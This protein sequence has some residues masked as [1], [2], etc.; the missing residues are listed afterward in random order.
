MGLG[1]FQKHR[2]EREDL[3]LEELAAAVDA[4]EGDEARA[5]AQ[6]ALDLAREH[7][8]RS[9][10]HLDDAEGDRPLVD[11]SARGVEVPPAD[12]TTRQDGETSADNGGQGNAGVDGDG[13]PIDPNA[14]KPEDQ[15]QGDETRQEGETS[16][17]NGGQGNAGV[18]GD[19]E[20]EDNQTRVPK[21]AGNGSREAW[22]SYAFDN[23]KTPED[24]DGLS[25]DDIRE[26]FAD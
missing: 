6:E 4:A 1:M 15:E 7:A 10:A 23:G 9:E 22:A 16:A 19:G 8:G 20:P 5:A 17:D 18:D 3:I 21:P 13:E 25:R 12:E 14:P 24:L 2:R 11:A 26:L